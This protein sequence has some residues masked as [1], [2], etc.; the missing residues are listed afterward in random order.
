MSLSACSF[1][2]TACV[3][4]P[5]QAHGPWRVLWFD[6]VEQGM[7]YHGDEGELRPLVV[8]FDYQRTLVAAAAAA[9]L[10][11][12]APRRVLL[13]GLGAGGWMACGESRREARPVLAA[14]ATPHCLHCGSC[15][16]PHDP[17]PYSTALG[18]PEL[19]TVSCACRQLRRGA[20]HPGWRP[21]RHLGGRD[22]R[23][24]RRD[25]ARCARA[26]DLVSRAACG[27]A[28]TCGGSGER[29]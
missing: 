4:H 17:V 15:H 9:L 23:D 7:T 14:H 13:V 12:D 1:S 2:R 22:R 27:T 26:A 16:T 11:A 5:R 20:P 24:R 25:R 10:P 3:P 21:P 29:E 19:R 8:G 28:A 6:R 18:S